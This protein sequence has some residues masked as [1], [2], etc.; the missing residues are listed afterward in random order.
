MNT[1]NALRTEAA[2]LGVPMSSVGDPRNAAVLLSAA[3]D[4]LWPWEWR[5]KRFVK[6]ALAHVPV[7]MAGGAGFTGTEAEAV[8]VAAAGVS[9]PGDSLDRRPQNPEDRR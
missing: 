1:T 6:S 9:C 2:R 8:R 7:A 3:H 4:S 5:R